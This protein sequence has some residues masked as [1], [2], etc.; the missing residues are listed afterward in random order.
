MC[1]IATKPITSMTMQAWTQAFGGWSRQ[2]KNANIR[3]S[4]LSR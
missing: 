1:H 3:V 2:S 4:M